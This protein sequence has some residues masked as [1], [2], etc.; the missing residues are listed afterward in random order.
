MNRLEAPGKA[1][2]PGPARVF[3]TVPG[4]DELATAGLCADAHGFIL[5]AVVR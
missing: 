2:S 5:H 1:G 3:R 4:R